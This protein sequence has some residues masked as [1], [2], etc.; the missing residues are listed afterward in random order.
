MSPMVILWVVS[1]YAG[2]AWLIGKGYFGELTGCAV[3]AGGIML[4][5]PA[6]CGPT[7]LLAAWLLPTRSRGR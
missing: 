7:L 2:A 1:G 4:L 6:V 3:L 5:F